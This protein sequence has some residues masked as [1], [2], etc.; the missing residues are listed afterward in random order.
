MSAISPA[1]SVS[2]KRGVVTINCPGKREAVKA[3]A[4]KMPL[5]MLPFLGKPIIAYLLDD[6]AKKGVGRVRLLVSDR[7]EA[8][9][10]Y[11]GAGEPWGLEVQVE[12]VEAEAPEEQ[13]FEVLPQIPGIRLWDSYASWAAALAR[14]FQ[15]LTSGHI[16]MRTVA[17]GIFVARTAFVS[18]EAELVAPCWIGPN[19][20]ISANAVVG[21]YSVVEDGAYVDNDSHI[22]CGIV[23]PRTYVG[24]S[25]DVCKSLAW[26]AQLVSLDDG[27]TI[28][29]S[30]T[31]MLSPIG[32]NAGGFFD[33]LR[34]RLISLLIS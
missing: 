17:P 25:L 14:G 27:A 4:A 13:G 7:A 12:E 22:T 9:Y 2:I 16:G 19:S 28:N 10:A 26:G 3:L 34:M 1:K 11:V 30:D 33:H 20:H 21:P 15:V 29:I 23:G 18:E 24:K 32:I 31:F 8:V 6:L 5:I